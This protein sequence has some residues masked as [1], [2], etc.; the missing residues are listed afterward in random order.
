MWLIIYKRKSCIVIEDK[1]INDTSFEKAEIQLNEKYIPELMKKYD[2]IISIAV[3]QLR[4]G[5][6]KVAVYKNGEILLDHPKNNLNSLSWYFDLFKKKYDKVE[7]IKQIRLLNEEL[8]NFKIA[9]NIRASLSSTFLICI[10]KGMCLS[11]TDDLDTIKTKVDKSL[12]KY[13]YDENLEDLNKWKK[14][15]TLN[16]RFLYDMQGESQTLT[17][18]NLFKIYEFIKNNIFNI[19]N[20]ASSDGYD[21]MSL[22]FSTFSRYALSNDKGQYFTP[23]HISDI[24]TDLLELDVNSIVLDPTCGSGTFLT[25]SM[26]KMIKLANNDQK[27]ISRIKKEQIYGIDND[28]LIVGLAMANMLLH[29]DGRS[30]I[31]TEDCFKYFSSKEKKEKI[32]K[33]IMNPPYGLWKDK[34]DSFGNPIKGKDGKYKKSQLSELKFLKET[35]KITEGN[36]L[37]VIILQTSCALG[38]KYKDERYD[39]MQNHSLKAVFTCAVDLFCPTGVSTCIMVWE[40]NK[41]HCGETYLANW[42]NDGF[43]KRRMGK[44]N[45]VRLD[46][47]NTWNDLKKEWLNNYKMKINGINIKLNDEDSWLYESH[48]EIDYDKELKEE[49]FIKTIRKY[50]SYKVEN[51]IKE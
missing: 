37:A 10:N 25:K 2:N 13:C 16:E 40:A 49:D 41:P 51:G 31:R 15:S 43:E 33:I 28:P 30:N 42:K 1:E 18:H 22:F 48:L 6:Y 5:S 46:V 3:K 26:D 17:K 36:A 21:V 20:Q 45:T 32:N 19:L 35:L 8:K 4:N 12:H 29:K 9:D 44:K 39:L 23:D 34:V 50:I 38:T 24:M 7:L 11:L 14:I 27:I 47:N